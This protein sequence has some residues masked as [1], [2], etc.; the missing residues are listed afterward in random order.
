MTPGAKI[1]DDLGLVY[2]RDRTNK[3]IN[4]RFTTPELEAA[5]ER[6]RDATARANAKAQEKLQVHPYSSGCPT[7]V[8]R[9][10]N[11]YGQARCF[12]HVLNGC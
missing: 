7:N 5:V 10:Y 4:D 3:E 8:F 12:H 9:Y 6:Y 11:R 2:A 1:P